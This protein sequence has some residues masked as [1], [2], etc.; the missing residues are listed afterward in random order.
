MPI[1]VRDQDDGATTSIPQKIIPEESQLSFVSE[2][3]HPL[4]RELGQVWDV[5]V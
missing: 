3:L 2:L 1:A 4:T 5:W